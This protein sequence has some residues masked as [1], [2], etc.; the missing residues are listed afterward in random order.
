MEPVT[1]TPATADERTTER[2]EEL[3][4]HLRDAA[5]AAA[6][7]SETAAIY[8]WGSVVS[9]DFRDEDSDVDVLV[10]GTAAPLPGAIEELR[11]TAANRHRLLERLDITVISL[12]DAADGRRGSPLDRIAPEVL[13]LQ[14][15]AWQH[16]WGRTDLVPRTRPAT[17]ARQLQLRAR[18]LEQRL[19]MH[20]ANAQ[21]EPAKFILKELGFIA[22]LL[23][24]LEFGAHPF[25]YDA[26]RSR[27]TAV[28]RPAVEALLDARA[29]GWRTPDDAQVERL[30]TELAGAIARMELDS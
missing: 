1:V 25:S 29:N 3:R 2:L 9:H 30:A 8:L 11:R 27:A 4:V 21:D 23:H 28:T 7:D 16:V 24:Q 14:A 15:A 20:R 6:L 22:H 12:T 13:F 5:A 19:R 26:L 17:L 10:I 18:S